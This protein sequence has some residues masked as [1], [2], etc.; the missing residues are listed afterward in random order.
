MS[1]WLRKDIR[2]RRR[3]FRSDQ[4]R[5]D[6][7]Q[8]FKKKLLT[9]IKKRRRTYNEFIIKKFDNENNPGNFFAHLKTLLSHNDTNKWSPTQMYPGE[10]ELAVA[11][12]LAEYYNDISSEYQP[13]DTSQLPRTF[14]R[15]LPLLLPSEVEDKMKKSKKN[16]LNGPWR[17][18]GDPV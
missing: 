8:A 5:S 16:L 1:D 15:Q 7:W 13:L 11:E 6:R 10:S 12:K 3:I 18:T 17:Y 2:S 4:G 14:S 9:K